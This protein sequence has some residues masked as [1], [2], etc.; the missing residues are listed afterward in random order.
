[1]TFQPIVRGM[2]ASRTDLFERLA[3][4]IWDLMRYAVVS[5]AALGL[6]CG[7]LFLLTRAGT[8]YQIAAAL[9]FLAGMA[10]AYFGSITLVFGDR[11]AH[12]RALEAGGF[13][14][15]GLLGLGLNQLLLFCFV[16][17]GTTLL[18]AKSLTAICVFFFN[19][20]A[21]RRLLFSFDK[22]FGP[23]WQHLHSFPLRRTRRK[24]LEQTRPGS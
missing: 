22:V 19:F 4:I 8:H 18:I 3:S 2:S 6:D 13:F 24:E 23:P 14:V 1:M 7:L 20:L 16:T 17:V 11:R 10:I 9:S 15:I 21:R 12:G 5:A